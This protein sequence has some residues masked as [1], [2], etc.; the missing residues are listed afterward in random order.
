MVARKL[1][2][3]H[4]RPSDDAGGTRQVRNNAHFTDDVSRT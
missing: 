4:V 1:E 3:D 2:R